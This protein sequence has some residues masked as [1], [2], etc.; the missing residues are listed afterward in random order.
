MLQGHV[1]H[2]DSRQPIGGMLVSDGRNLCRTDASGYFS[3]PGWEHAHLVYVCALTHA[4]NDWFYM[5]ENHESDYDFYLSP[6][7]APGAHS[8]LHFSDT[9]IQEPCGEWLDFIK[10]YTRKLSPDFMI[11]TGD[12]YGKLGL[13]QHY[14]DMNESTMGCPVR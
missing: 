10:K 6:V 14:L 11:Q 13:E 4:H 7:E 9:E 5:I 2:K 1:Y 8:F 3:L 12:I